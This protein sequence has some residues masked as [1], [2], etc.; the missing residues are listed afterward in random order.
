MAIENEKKKYKSPIKGH[1]DFLIDEKED[2]FE[3]GSREP[4]RHN[5]LRCPGRLKIFC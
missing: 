2:E 4:A 1:L 5:D 3:G